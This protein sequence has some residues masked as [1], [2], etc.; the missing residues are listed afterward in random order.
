MKTSGNEN[1][2]EAGE[3]ISTSKIKGVF[4][5]I[6]LLFLFQVVIFILHKCG[7]ENPVASAG[8]TLQKSATRDMVFYFNPN[9]IPADSLQLLGLTE[10]Q[11][12]TIVHYREKGGKFRKKEDFKKMY[13]VSDEFYNKVEAYIILPTQKTS[14][15]PHRPLQISDNRQVTSTK[16]PSQPVDI[17]YVTAVKKSN[18]PKPVASRNAASTTAA[19]KAATSAYPPTPKVF[20]DLNEADSIAL[21]SVKGIGPYFAKKILQ[22]R[23]ALGSYALPEQLMEINGI[24]PE[25]FE[26]LK[27][28]VFVHPA[29]VKK[30]ALTMQNYEFLKKHPYIGAYA[31]R[32][33]KL[34]LEKRDAT[35]ACSLKELVENNLITPETAEKLSPYIKK[36][37]AD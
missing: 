26:F 30:F 37:T 22:Y 3:R 28:Q 13:S 35:T 17:Q 15:P 16:K 20:I 32:G 7:S 9:T 1:D 12:L 8:G 14:K 11:A 27:P 18:A 4:A 34:Y 10:K 21:V 2:F 33:I 24:T 19:Q 29:G 25:K 36:S 5:L 6:L 31:A 23:S